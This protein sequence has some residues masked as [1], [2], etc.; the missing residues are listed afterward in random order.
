MIKITKINGEELTLNSELIEF[1]EETPDTMISLTT[2]KKIIVM[3]S[4]AEIVNRVI[5]FKSKI[6]NYCSEKSTL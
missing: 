6:Y 1:I 3:E 4:C 2:G 5:V